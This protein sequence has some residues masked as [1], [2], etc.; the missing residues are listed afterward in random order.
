MN[1]S[2]EY[3]QE[4]DQNVLWYL[5]NFNIF[6]NFSGSEL[7]SVKETLKIADY[8]KGETVL[9]PGEDHRR[10]YFLFEGKVKLLRTY[11]GGK[12]IIL[13]I[14]SEGELFGLL[15]PL[16]EDY[17][18]PLVVALEK[19]LVAS[20]HEQDFFSLMEQKSIFCLKIN[21][22]VG[23]RVLKI[24]N[25]LDE[26]IF[27]AI[28]NRLA[29]ILLRLATEFPR[30]RDCG[31][32]INLKLNQEEIANLIGATRESTSTA[33]NRFKRKGWIEFHDRYICVHDRGAL[34][35]LVE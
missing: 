24:E 1:A 32:S 30:R 28:P 8:E 19:C 13:V 10:I 3:S 31:V 23:E 16:L 18:N 27:L 4:D 35:A 7:E 29:R 11:T 34:Q 6:D 22:Y 26:L 9:L 33:L 21:K 15:A 14:L 2:S 25:R 20:M 5:K 17:T 12:E